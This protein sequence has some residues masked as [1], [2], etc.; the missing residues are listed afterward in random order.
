MPYWDGTNATSKLKPTRT[1]KKLEPFTIRIPL[2]ATA[3]PK[4]CRRAITLRRISVKTQ[5]ED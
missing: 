1:A 3:R 2:N 4:S 5:D